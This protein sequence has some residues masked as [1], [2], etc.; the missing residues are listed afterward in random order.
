MKSHRRD[1]DFVQSLYSR[2]AFLAIVAFL[3][4]LAISN[5]RVL[6]AR[7]GFDSR[8]FHQLPCNQSLKPDVGGDSAH[9]RISLQ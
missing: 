6:K 8:R 5:L 1:L 3:A 2:C 4:F 7:H 9:V